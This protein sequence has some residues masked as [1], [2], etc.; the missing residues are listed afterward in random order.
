MKQKAKRGLLEKRRTIWERLIFSVFFV[1][2]LIWSAIVLYMLF[3]ALM[4]AFKANMDYVNEPLA[5]PKVL[6]FEN[7]G[8]AMSKLHHNGVEFWGM[9]YNSLWQTVLPTLISTTMTCVTGYVFAHYKFKGR[10]LMFAIVMFIMIIPIYGNFAAEYKLN[11]DLGLNDS[12]LFLVRSFG[13][14]G[15]NMLLTYGYYKG[16]PKELRE[17]VY[18]DGGT[19]YAALFKV[20]FPLGRNV[21]VAL[22]LLGFI[23]SWNDY[24]TPLLYM[25]KM[26]NLALGLYNFQQEIQ[27]V[28]NNPAYF[29]GTLIV[30]LPILL[31]FI[32]GSDKIMGQLFSGG[33]KG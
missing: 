15:A 3:W 18:M 19:D 2:L 32:Y 22:A 16:I 27:Y 8:I 28:A 11:Y 29:A 21:F 12:Y 24:T 9:L 30:M 33:L 7:F 26:P 6:H 13:G 10:D 31:V 17:A 1:V 23:A 5:L 14:L 25:D 4:S 20:Y